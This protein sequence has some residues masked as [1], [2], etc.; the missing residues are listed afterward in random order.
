MAGQFFA[1]AYPIAHLMIAAPIA[2]EAAPE[3]MFVGADSPSHSVRTAPHDGG[4]MLVLAGPSFK[5]GHE[6][7]V[8]EGYRKL[9]A[10]GRRHFPIGEIAYRWFNEDYA[11][12]D[13]VPF[14][15]R[16]AARKDHVFV[17]TGFKAWGLT[18]SMVAAEILTDL[19]L[20]RSNPWAG[21][22]DATRIKPAASAKEFVTEN[23]HVARYWMR[24]RLRRGAEMSVGDLAPGEAAILHHGGEKVAAFRDEGGELH[25]VSAVCTHMGCDVS[26]NNAERSW[27]C[28]CHGSRFDH[29]GRVIHGPAVRDLAPKPIAS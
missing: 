13:G 27:D 16:A 10:F 20:D 6:A 21:L 18:T 7:D 9:I 25:A 14:I 4:R 23:F 3:G 26:W 28:A 1:K 24:D 17:A 2:A 8:A 19:V 5:P 29:Q 12:M 22:F 15:G 11:S